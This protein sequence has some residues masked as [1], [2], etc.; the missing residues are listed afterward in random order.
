MPS[1][2]TI[3]FSAIARSVMIS[4][5]RFRLSSAGATRFSAIARSV[6]ISALIALRI[7]HNRA[8]VSVL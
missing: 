2:A 8:V 7:L 5:L 3:R 1:I 6:M 4:A